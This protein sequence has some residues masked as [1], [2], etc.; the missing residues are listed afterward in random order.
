MAF[1]A[2][3]PTGDR[4]DG[5]S[6]DGSVDGTDGAAAGEV[7]EQ[8][9][10]KAAARG[11]GMTLATQG[12]RVLLQLC[13]VVL[14]ARLLTPQDFGRIAMV[15]SVI[16]VADL[17]R[18]AGLSSAAVQAKTL[19][20]AER[21]NLFWANLGLGVVAAA[22][23]AACEPLIVRGYGDPTLGAIVFSLC[24]VFIV[25][26]ANTQFRADLTRRL[27]FG[28]L[29][30]S[31][32]GSQAAGIVVAIALAVSGAGFWAIVAQQVVSRSSSSRSTS[33]RRG[34]SPAAGTA[35]SRCATSSASAAGCW[36]PRRSTTRPATST[37][38]PWAPT[39]A[40][41]SSASTRGRTSCS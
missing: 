30:L 39:S 37:T 3:T 4:P 41:P 1:R 16:G 18:D 20:E 2:G 14:L 38:S 5:G 27:R 12:V 6:D 9:L 24:G 7:P 40:R 17:L 25:S 11:T 21:T 15:A 26:G 23:T 8:S 33:G 29:A 34:G 35:G 10:G 13:S 32:V 31:D 19:S 22:A 36:E 28:S